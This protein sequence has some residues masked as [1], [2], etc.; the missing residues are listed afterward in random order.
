M[1]C[2][3][4]LGPPAA[5]PS[6]MKRHVELLAPAMALICASASLAKLDAE[7]T[8]MSPDALAVGVYQLKY[9]STLVQP[10]PS[11]VMSQ[12]TLTSTPST[13]MVYVPSGR[14]GSVVWSSRHDD[15]SG[16][17]GGGGDGDGGGGDG[18]GGA[19]EGGGGEGEGGGGDGE[20]GDGEGGWG[21]IEGE[22]TTSAAELSWSVHEFALCRVANTLSGRLWVSD[23]VL[24][25]RLTSSTLQVTVSPSNSMRI[26][27]S[28][29]YVPRWV[30][31]SEFA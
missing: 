17:E 4:Q 3:L 29:S 12:Y 19:G 22:I 24:V 13:W 26:S 18:E 15:T 16:G 7:D 20:G 6:S 27:V 1:K 11:D 8:A 31:A 28:E 23:S 30:Y 25:I 5:S 2:R 21:K 14:L 9:C 10:P